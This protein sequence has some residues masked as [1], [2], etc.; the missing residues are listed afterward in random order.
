[1][2][3]MSHTTKRIFPAATRSGCWIQIRAVR[4]VLVLAD[5]NVGHQFTNARSPAQGSHSATGMAQRG[6]RRAACLPLLQVIAVGRL[7]ILRRRRRGRGGTIARCGGTAAAR[8][9]LP[10]PGL[11]HSGGRRWGGR[12]RGCA[13]ARLLHPQPIHQC[14]HPGRA[15]CTFGLSRAPLAWKL[16]PKSCVTHCIGVHV[17]GRLNK[18]RVE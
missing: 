6:G 13:R 10:A 14:R 12:R 17:E 5:H 15:A 18:P 7:Q 3:E 11:P 9:A 2:A 4:K 8:G 16:S 1:M